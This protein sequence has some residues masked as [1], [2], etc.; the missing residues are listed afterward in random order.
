MKRDH[1]PSAAAILTAGRTLLEEHPPDR[2]SVE[3]V[4]AASGF[5]RQAVYRNFG[6][7]AGLLAALLEHIDAVEDA[8][9]GVDHVLEG[10]SGEECI[11][12]LF[13]WWA[14]YVPRFAG[15][16]RGV[17]AQDMP[18]LISRPRGRIG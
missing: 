1:P 12:R 4:A 3:M 8:R 5:S 14:G 11:D 16:A 18:I 17:L 7:R 13:A 6:S 2:V 15:V 9:A 10:S